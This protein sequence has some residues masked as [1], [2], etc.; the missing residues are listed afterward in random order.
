MKKRSKIVVRIMIAFV[1]GLALLTFFSNTIMNATIPKV[2]AEYASRG[3]LSFTNSATTTIV[4]ENRTDIKGIEGRTIDEVFVSSYDVVNKGDVIA[5]LKPIE[6]TASL[7][8]LKDQL[9]SL[10]REAEYESRTPNHG[11]DYSSYNDAIDMAQETL[12]EAQNTLTQVQNKDATISEAQGIIDSKAADVVAL[13][14]S[15]ASASDTVE[16]LNAQIAEIDAQIAPLQSQIEVYEALGTPTPTPSPTPGADPTPTV[17]PSVTPAAPTEMEILWQ[18]ICDLNDQRAVLEEELTAAEAR[19]ADYSGQL[20][21]VN[22]TIEEAQGRIDALADLPSLSS[23]Q[24][25]VAS[26]QRGLSSARTSLSDAVANAGI[27]ADRAQDAIDDRNKEIEKLEEQIAELEEK[28]AV[29]EIK[30]PAAGY[31]YNVA[32][33]S[34]DTM[35]ANQVIVTIIPEDTNEREC[36]ATFSFEASAVRDLY[37]G[38]ELEVTSG[39]WDQTC[40]IASIKPDPTNPRELRQV[41][42]VIEGESWPDEQI[43][44]RASQSNQNY[45][46]VIP[47]GAVNEDNSGTFVYVIEGSSGPLGDKFTVRRVDVTV[48]AEGGGMTAISGEGLS[49]YNTRIVIRAEEPLE[50]G[51]RVRLEDYKSDKDS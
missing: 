42:C 46:V 17:D 38:D 5:T 28:M 32:V 45:E 29:T 48:E 30:A 10:Q 23:A 34:G 37:V 19:L 8:E 21:S 11:T 7:D 27:E 14:A 16:D 47:S 15:V 2:M 33:A 51:Q 36:T 44:V 26:A 25:A 9:E 40:T 39:Y 13:E 35:E 24:N 6:D 49:D 50:D 43:T 31:V 4:V 12:T 18:Q 22:G 20:A 1:A 3:N 41:K